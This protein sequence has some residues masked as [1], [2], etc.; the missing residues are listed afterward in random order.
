MTDV[1][2]KSRKRQLL[3]LIWTNDLGQSFTVSFDAMVNAHHR[4]TSTVTD[5]P[6][7]LGKNASDHI[8]PDPDVLSFQGVITNTPI[9]LPENFADGAR[10]IQ[11]KVDGADKTIGNTVGRVVPLVGAAAAR[12]KLPLPKDQATVLKVFHLWDRIF[13]EL[14]PA[15][16]LAIRK[17]NYE[18][19]FDAARVKVRAWE[20]ANLH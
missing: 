9:V 3:Q 15:A 13:A 7:E 14:T 17:G 2:A 10:A 8:R 19:L 12:A 16:S 11:V 4:F 5:H 20:K 18:K 1:P 6:I